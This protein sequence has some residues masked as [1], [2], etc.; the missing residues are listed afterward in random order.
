L[1]TQ[2]NGQLR[3][4][5]ASSSTTRKRHYVTEIDKV[6]DPQVKFEP[7]SGSG[8]EELAALRR[9]TFSDDSQYNQQDVAVK[10]QAQTPQRT[11]L[12]PSSLLQRNAAPVQL[13]SRF[14]TSREVT[15]IFLS[16]CIIVASY[17]LSYFSLF[18]CVLKNMN[19]LCLT[20]VYRK[21]GVT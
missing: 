15:A 17:M 6:K 21:K 7:K 3:S 10:Q 11:P 9:H 8:S 18:V 16:L 19:K 12:R 5:S 1:L 4:H 14:L 13:Q 2:S 20:A